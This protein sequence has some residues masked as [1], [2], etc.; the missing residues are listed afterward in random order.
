[1]PEQ[2]LDLLHLVLV[3]HLG[4][5]DPQLL[6]V[7]A[8]QRAAFNQIRVVVHLLPDHAHQALVAAAV[9][10]HN[11]AV[12]HYLEVRPRHADAEARAIDLQVPSTLRVARDGGDRID[13]R[14]LVA[15]AHGAGVALLQVHRH[16]PVEVAADAGRRQA[17]DL[18]MGHRDGAVDANVFRPS[19]RTVR[20]GVQ[21]A[22]VRS[23]VVAGQS[24]L[25]VAGH[26]GVVRAGAAQVGDH[27]D[28]VPV[29]RD[30]ASES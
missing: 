19:S 12:E 26:V 15:A 3:H 29:E 8:I 28:A 24:D 30:E 6:Q 5:S 10:S 20:D 14:A 1:V 25:L 18:V 22:V 27:G 4:D 21:E 16:G 2:H 23:K 7:A 11:R 17:N 9:N 13:Y